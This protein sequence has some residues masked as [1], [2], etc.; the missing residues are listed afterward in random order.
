[1]SA[2]FAICITCII[3]YADEYEEIHESIRYFGN[4]L[5]KYFSIFV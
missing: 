5:K 1:M 4:V 3:L 2:A